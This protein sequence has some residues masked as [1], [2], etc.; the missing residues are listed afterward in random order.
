MYIKI[1]KYV[2]RI[3]WE[4]N[5]EW[6]NPDEGGCCIRLEIGSRVGLILVQIATICVMVQNKLQ[7]CLTKKLKGDCQIPVFDLD[8]A[9]QAERI[10]CNSF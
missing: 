8:L 5:Q 3:R 1:T 2:Q 7:S 6:V 10:H 4:T 9:I